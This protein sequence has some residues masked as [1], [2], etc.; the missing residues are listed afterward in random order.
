M[1]RL[2]AQI[3]SSGTFEPRYTKQFFEHNHEKVKLPDE[4]QSNDITEGAAA[5]SH[6]T[7]SLEPKTAYCTRAA[8]DN[9]FDNRLIHRL[10]K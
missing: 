7:G 6:P 3:Q 2:N 9:Y 5:A 1:F 8:S 10:L 4:T